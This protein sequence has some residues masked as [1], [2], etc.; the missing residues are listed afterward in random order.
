MYIIS[1]T[2]HNILI[3]WFLNY[4]DEVKLA[5]QDLSW[6][7]DHLTDVAPNWINFG[8]SLNVP[9]SQ[10]KI[11][12]ENNPRNCVNCLRE[13]LNLWLKNHPNTGKLLKALSAESVGQKQLASALEKRLI[14]GDHRQGVH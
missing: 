4:T 10:M 14:H 8:L 12:E 1:T 5:S 13:T 7:L 2:K 3:V 11:I 6:L 9:I